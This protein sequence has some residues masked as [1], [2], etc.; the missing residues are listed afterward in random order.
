MPQPGDPERAMINPL[1]SSPMRW[2]VFGILLMALASCRAHAQASTAEGEPTTGSPAVAQQ[3]LPASGGDGHGW[4]ALPGEAALTFPTLYH[5]PPGAE[6]GTVR[7]GPRLVNFPEMIASSED[8]V[9]LVMPRERID[10]VRRSDASG[11]PEAASEPTTPARLIRRVQTLRVVKTSTGTWDY[12]PRGR[13]PIALPSLPGRGELR[14][15]VRSEDSLFALIQGAP[16]DESEFADASAREDLFL[17]LREGEARWESFTLPSGWDVESSAA[18]VASANRIVLLQGDAAWQAPSRAAAR[19]VS[20]MWSPVDF[21]TEMSGASFATAGSSIIVAHAEPDRI[22]LDLLREG[23]TTRLGVIDHAAEQYAIIGGGD[24][25]TVIW[26]GEGDRTR[27]RATVIS[28]ITGDVL[29]DDYAKTN[30]VVS[31]REIQSLGLLVGALMLTILVFVLRPEE[32]L[33]GIVLLPVGYAL[34]SPLRRVLAVL[35]DLAPSLV[36]AALIFHVSGQELLDAA[37]LSDSST[38]RGA[39]ALGTAFLVTGIHST[40]GEWLF[41][42]T[43][44]K[45]ICRCRTISVRGERPKLWQAALRTFVKLLFPPFALFLF[46]DLRRRHPGDLVAGTAVIQRQRPGADDDED[47][48]SPS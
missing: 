18:I 22:A 44:G 2:L 25:L 8:R 41:G 27:L 32:A 38:T 31:G 35:L 37:V 9:V 43:I 34:A 20:G 30:A 29:F 19:G 46:L 13:E 33:G 28:A 3:R 48:P 42:R 7:G 24:L 11:K 6:P 14:G 40:L 12:L 45:A 1:V 36:A 21:D 16:R 23:T 17:V 15:V 26:R 39:L 5:L 47:E 4:F 10:P